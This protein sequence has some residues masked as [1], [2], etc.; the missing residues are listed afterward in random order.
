MI[1]KFYFILGIDDHWYSYVENVNFE[2]LQNATSWHH[3]EL[4]VKEHE[5]TKELALYACI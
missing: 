2:P 1:F 5:Y 3:Q 4:K